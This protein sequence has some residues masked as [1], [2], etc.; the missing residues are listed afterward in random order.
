LKKMTDDMNRLQLNTVVSGAMKIF[1]TLADT[2]SAALRTETIDILIRTLNPIT[3]HICHALWIALGH[4]D[5][6]HDAPWPHYD[7]DA[8]SQDSIEM[9]IQ[10]NGKVRGK[11]QLPADAKQS[12]IETMALANVN[13]QR[14]ING[15]RMRKII[16]VPKKLI[17]I[18]V[19][20]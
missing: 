8:L 16:V 18:V 4:G 7:A 11:I 13:V 14:F 17:N 19:S 6:I 10:V 9:V 15:A 12:T 5:A 3:P 2:Q 20:S 1:N